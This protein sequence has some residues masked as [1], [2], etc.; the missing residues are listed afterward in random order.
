MQLVGTI[1]DI[2]VQKQIEVSPSRFKKN[3]APT[4]FF[5]PFRPCTST[6]SNKGPLTLSPIEN[7]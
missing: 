5:F 6:R 4:D 7:L 1:T 3:L 2:S